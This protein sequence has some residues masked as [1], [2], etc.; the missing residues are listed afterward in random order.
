VIVDRLT[1]Y[2]RSSLL[3]VDIRASLVYTLTKI[4]V[5]SAHMKSFRF[6]SSR[7]LVRASNN[8]LCFPAGEYSTA[9]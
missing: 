9:D 8:V 6:S 1:T 7:F 2:T 5:T 4:T 3:Q